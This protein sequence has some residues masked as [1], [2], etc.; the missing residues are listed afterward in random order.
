MVGRLINSMQINQ[1]QKYID[2]VLKGDIQAFTYLVEAYKDYVYTI[3]F[4]IVKITHKCTKLLT[5][6]YQICHTRPNR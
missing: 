6:W 4:N 2:R 3:A 1:D 5:Q